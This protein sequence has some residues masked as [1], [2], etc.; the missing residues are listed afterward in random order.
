MNTRT[1][2]VSL[3]ADLHVRH[4][5]SIPSNSPEHLSCTSVP[6]RST[7]WIQR[8]VN[9]QVGPMRQTSSFLTCLFRSPDDPVASFCAVS[10]SQQVWHFLNTCDHLKYWMSPFPPNSA[11]HLAHSFNGLAIVQPND[12]AIRRRWLCKHI[13]MRW[14]PAMSCP[15]LVSTWSSIK[16]Y[17]EQCQFRGVE[18]SLLDATCCLW[19]VS[20]WISIKISSEQ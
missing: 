15:F 8:Q 20:S 9:A 5:T 1:I 3:G 14:L 4:I 13:S 2:S 7:Y 18:E 16:I 6:T 12:R 17:S 10:P 19:K 11:P